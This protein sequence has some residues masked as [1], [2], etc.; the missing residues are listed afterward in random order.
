MA[1]QSLGDLVKT[2]EELSGTDTLVA[3][4]YEERSTGDKSEVERKFFEVSQP[5][6]EHLLVCPS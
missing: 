6:S 1:S 2:L 4:S 5:F 3:M